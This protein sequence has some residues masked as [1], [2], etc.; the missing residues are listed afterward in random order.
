[1]ALLLDALV[2]ALPLSGHLAI[3]VWSYNRLHTL[4]LRPRWIKRSERL[5]LALGLLLAGALLLSHRD[6]A[7]ALPAGSDSRDAPGLRQAASRALTEVGTFYRPWAW[8]AAAVA[9]P[10]WLWPKMWRHATRR[11]VSNDTQSLDVV[12]QLGF[13]PAASWRTRLASRLPG[14]QLFHLAIQRKTILLPRRAAT[15][16]AGPAEAWDG[17]KIAHL[18]DLHLTGQLT[19]PYYEVI[20]EQTLALQPDL[21]VLTGDIL[22]KEACLSWVEPL[23]GRLRAPLGCYFVL[24]NHELRLPDVTRLRE[25]LVTAGW[26]DLGGRQHL[27][28]WRGGTIRLEGCEWPWHGKRPAWL[29]GFFDRPRWNFADRS[30]AKSD[31]ESAPP[32]A[33]LSILLTHTPDVLPFARRAGFDL[34]LAG[35]NHGGQICL[36]LV[37]PWIVPSRFGFRY[38]GGLYEEPPVLLHVSRGLG[39][40]HPVRLRCPPELALLVLR[41]ADTPPSSQTGGKP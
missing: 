12:R 27:C 37:G 29:P 31:Q 5:I 15:W 39:S 7:D 18:S 41:P 34:V 4:P 26:T 33:D 17:L 32:Q 9:V 14:N 13:V 22:E 23:F 20:V 28:S 10:C 25:A 6:S 21:I 19:Q 11:L 40:T 36:P 2:L 3:L 24:G 35:H 38:A 30:S 8:A 1:M 16:E